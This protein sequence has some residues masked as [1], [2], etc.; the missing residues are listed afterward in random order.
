[1]GTRDDELLFAAEL[2]EQPQPPT[3]KITRLLHDARWKLLVVD[4]DADIHAVTK[5]VFKDFSFNNQAIEM[6]NAQSAQQAEALLHVHPDI[7]LA[8]IDVVMETENAGLQLVE[9]IRHQLKNSLMRLLLRTGQPGQ[10][11]EAHVIQAYDINGYLEK[12][13][14]TAQKLISAVT[15]ALRSYVQISEQ[16]QQ[17]EKLRIHAEAGEKAKQAFVA[18]ISHE[19]RTPLNA[20]QG[21]V[22]NLLQTNPTYNQQSALNIILDSSKHLTTLIDD[23]LALARL[24]SETQSVQIETLYLPDFLREIIE[25]SRHLAELAEVHWDAEV[26]QPMPHE[27]TTDGQLLRQILLRLLNNAIKFATAQPHGQGRVVLRVRYEAQAIHFR[28][29]DNGPGMS[30]AEKQ[31]AFAAFQQGETRGMKNQGLGIGLTLG[32]KYLRLLGTDLQINCVQQQ[33]CRFQFAL[34]LSAATPWGEVKNAC[35]VAP[36]KSRR[37]E[38]APHGLPPAPSLEKLQSLYELAVQGYLQDIADEAER[39][40]EWEPRFHR[41]A[42]ELRRLSEDFEKSKLCEYLKA[43]LDA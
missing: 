8:L 5:L 1:M 6:L 27:L 14:L 25:L 15:T 18:N 16:S 24:E 30:D 29:E 10:A 36:K 19:I 4:D 31:Q 42:D 9:Y 26:E 37:R 33:G 28:I 32:Q 34:P 11:P 3:E 17:L 20:I 43:Y 2:P 41:F 39:L 7:H 35:G 21:F 38:I 13:E 40:H 12:T 22:Q 23:L